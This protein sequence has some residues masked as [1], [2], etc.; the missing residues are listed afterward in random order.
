MKVSPSCYAHLVSSLMGLASGKIAVILEVSKIKKCES[1][2]YLDTFSHVCL[3]I[4][5]LTVIL[6]L[7][8][9]TARG[10]PAQ[11]GGQLNVGSCIKLALSGLL[12]QRFTPQGY[13]ALNI[14]CYYSYP[15]LYTQ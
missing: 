13:T 3:I 1:A 12:A 8:K 2:C 4:L 14:H 9:N 15:I 6:F 5:I 7:H 10:H 11:A